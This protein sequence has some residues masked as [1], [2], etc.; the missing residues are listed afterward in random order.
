MTNGSR[1]RLRV[2]HIGKYYWPHRGGIETYLRLLCQRMRDQV[3]LRVI[4]ANDCRCSTESVVDDVAVTRLGTAF[5]FAS[6]PVCPAMVQKIRDTEA[7][8]VHF[9]FPNPLGLIAYLASGHKGRLVV[10][11][12]S[13]VIRQRLLGKAFEPILHHALKRASAVIATSPN[14]IDS[15]AI[16]SSYRERCHVVPFGIVMEEFDS[17]DWASV[18]AIRRQYG[19]RLVLSVGR[20]V[21]YKGFEYLIRAMKRVQG[22]LLIVGDGPLHGALQNLAVQEGVGQR[23]IFLN[24][25]ED[26]VPYY[27]A[28]DLFVLASS[29]RSEA[30]G[31]VQLEAMASGKPV[32]NTA[33]RSGVPYVSVHGSTGLTVPPCD[34]GSLAAAINLLLDDNDLRERY[35]RAARLRASREFSLD[36]MVD[37]TFLLYQQVMGLKRPRLGLGVQN[38]M[39]AYYKSG[40]I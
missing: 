4:V 23:V 19:P 38:T 6:A 21:Y 8:L 11:Y 3:D 2:L 30:F 25:I 36:R 17:P 7:D 9:H 34:A 15:S 32:V 10:S 33:L 31:I 27:H 26:V 29:A 16:L 12:H 14:Y 35:G 13:D 22:T 37:R 28:A 39:D 24:E 1:S 5:R 20:L 18:S 40:T